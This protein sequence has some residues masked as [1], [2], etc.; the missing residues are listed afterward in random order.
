MTRALFVCTP[1]ESRRL[2]AKAVVKMDEV[3][4]ALHQSN[5]LI[6]HGPTNVY[7]LEELLGKERLS[8]LM[9]PSTYATGMIT[10]GILCVSAA[11]R[12][13][14]MVLLKRGVVTPP[15]ATVSEILRDFDSHSV[16]IKGASA[17]DADGNAG[18]FVAN[19]E[20]GTAGMAIGTILAR[21]IRLIAAVGLEKLVPSVRQAVS[22][23]GQDT[24]DYVQGLRVGMIPLCNAKVVTEIEAIKILTG[25]AS[26]HV[27]SGG[28]N[29]S[30]GS[31][32]L[33]AE[34][35]PE[36]ISKTIDL[37]ESIKGEPARHI[38]AASCKTCVD[39]P[40]ILSRCQFRGKKGEELPAFVRN[41]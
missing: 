16:V 11:G 2:I 30:E 24:F 31:V 15:P 21:G 40:Q 34:G 20:G 29:G 4:Y 12:N 1:G 23:C 17:I 39:G 7:I 27:A 14:P 32:V 41:R 28:I 26:F 33:V 19:R 8:E 10:E 22:L 13:T 36:A 35:K 18:V 25:V 6:P 37:I 3:Q 5:M 9:N 38:P